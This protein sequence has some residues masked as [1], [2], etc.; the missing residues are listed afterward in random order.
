MRSPLSDC[1]LQQG[2]ALLTGQRQRFFH[3]DMLAR[4]QRRLADFVVRGGDGQVDH[5][6]NIRVSE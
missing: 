1:G 2:A 4:V 3:I 6:L 5:E